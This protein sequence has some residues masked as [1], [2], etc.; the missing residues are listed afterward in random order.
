MIITISYRGRKTELEIDLKDNIRTIL[1]K[2]YDKVNWK[3]NRFYTKE[4]VILKGG[5]NLLNSD[6]QCL[7]VTAEELGFDDDDNLTLL[8]TKEVNAGKKAIIFI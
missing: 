4:E 2:Y 8:I 7:N 1:D 6:E 5:D 3:G